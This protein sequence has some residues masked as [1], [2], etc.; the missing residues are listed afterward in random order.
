MINL[1]FIKTYKDGRRDLGG[2][3]YKYKSFV[4]SSKVI[5]LLRSL[6]L[7]LRRSYYKNF[8]NYVGG[9]W[10]N[11]LQRSVTRNAYGSMLAE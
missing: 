3:M 11:G 2:F 10:T 1:K 6:R 7:A 5:I 8:F 9:S 4:I